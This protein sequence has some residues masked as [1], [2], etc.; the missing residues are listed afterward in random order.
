MPRKCPECGGQDTRSHEPSCSWANLEGREEF[1]R[2]HA[3]QLV[4]ERDKKLRASARQ[5]TATNARNRYLQREVARLQA[6][7]VGLAERVVCQSD[8]LSQNAERVALAVR[9]HQE[10]APAQQWVVE[11]RQMGQR[12]SVF[13]TIREQGQQ[14]LAVAKDLAVFLG[15]TLVIGEG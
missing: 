15:A 2:A 6:I 4:Q 11:L 8:Q 9:I 10:T 13:R 5:I 1:V 7:V 12:L 14:A 3:V